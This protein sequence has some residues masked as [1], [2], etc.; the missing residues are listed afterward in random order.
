MSDPSLRENLW[1]ALTWKQELGSLSLVKSGKKVSL[2]RLCI[3]YVISPDGQFLAFRGHGEDIYIMDTKT[4]EFVQDFSMNDQCRS[5][6]PHDLYSPTSLPK[7]L[8]KEWAVSRAVYLFHKRNFSR[9][10]NKSIATASTIVTNVGHSPLP[11]LAITTVPTFYAP[12]APPP[13]SCSSLS[14]GMPLLPTIH[15][16]QHVITEPALQPLI[17]TVRGGETTAKKF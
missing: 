8:W 7:N 5:I 6:L 11:S 4:K 1:N 15:S 2:G 14:L 13:S 16:H 12:P 3:L 17:R 10:F 9:R